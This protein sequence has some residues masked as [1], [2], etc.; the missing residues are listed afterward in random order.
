MKSYRESSIKT[1]QAGIHYIPDIHH[2]RQK[3]LDTW[4]PH[5]K[6]LKINWLVL[7]AP[8]DWAVPEYFIEGL[9]A[10]NIQ[11][12][13][14]LNYSLGDPPRPADIS[15]V[16]EAYAH[17]GIK[18]LILFDRP[19]NRTAWPS[20]G[21]AR[22]DLVERFL[23]RFI[24]LA[25]LALVK[26]LIPVFPA[27]EPGG[28]YWDTT[29]LQSSLQGL[30]NRRQE[31]LLQ[32]MM[33]AVY[34]HTRSHHLN[35]GA[36]G[37]QQ[38][39]EA[40]PYADETDVQD[41]RGFRNFD[42]VN[43]SVESVLGETRPII[44]LEAGRCS[45]E[46]EET[47]PDNLQEVTD[48]NLAIWKLLAGE[49][50]ANPQDPE[51][52]L[53]PV[54]N[55]VI[56]CNFWLLT[57]PQAGI[58]EHYAWYSYDHS[59]S[60][61]VSQ[62]LMKQPAHNQKGSFTN[63]DIGLKDSYPGNHE[64]D[65]K[66]DVDFDPA[67]DFDTTDEAFSAAREQRVEDTPKTQDSGA[68]QAYAIQHYVLLPSFEWGISDFYLDAIRPFVK[69]NRATVGFSI[70]EA[71]MAEYVTVIGDESEFSEE[72]LEKM[73]FKGAVVERISGDG[74]TIASVLSQR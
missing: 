21:W 4:L 63:D 28:D 8:P 62:L 24:P 71:A 57:N 30:R 53:A 60:A 25:S 27:L 73:R 2:Y 10:E 51:S 65:L 7:E 9:V 48:N 3:D 31:E 33:L 67:M 44:L 56:A 38:W 49:T 50:T 42:W 59:P 5:L 6:D 64:V 18:H 68:E 72:V 46:K 17:W 11:P 16:W 23:D 37:P 47:N 1:R 32:N 15:P 13:L 70:S 29:F 40:K 34:A 12:I 39:K 66:T 43:A 69:K 22:Q 26:S 58:D 45:G 61:T 14:R 52:T 55:N 20:S 36:H 41:Q 74:T 35:W 54:P 19:N